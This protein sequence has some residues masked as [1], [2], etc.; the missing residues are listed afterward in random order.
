MITHHMYIY[1][2][3]H[4]LEKTNPPFSLYF[5]IRVRTTGSLSL[6]EDSMCFQGACFKNE[7]TSSDVKTRINQ[8]II[9]FVFAHDDYSNFHLIC[10]KMTFIFK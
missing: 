3:L 5:D 1:F 10:K 9:D 2:F 8:D 4:F 7:L 6:P